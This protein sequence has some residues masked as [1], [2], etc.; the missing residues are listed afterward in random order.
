MQS[1]ILTCQIPIS[2]IKKQTREPRSAAVYRMSLNA[3]ETQIISQITT[4]RGRTRTDSQG[5]S[6]RRT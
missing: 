2:D 1:V 5:C 3:K 6:C 4:H